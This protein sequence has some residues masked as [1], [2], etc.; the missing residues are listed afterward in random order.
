MNEDEQ[1]TFYC[2]YNEKNHMLGKGMVEGC[3]DA[4]EAIDFVKGE[5]NIDRVLVSI[6]GGKK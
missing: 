4:R 1:H 3:R 2:Y 6:Q 5:F